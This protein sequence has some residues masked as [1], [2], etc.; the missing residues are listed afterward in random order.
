[1]TAEGCGPQVTGTE[2]LPAGVLLNL[3]HTLPVTDVR[4]H[5]QTHTF[6]VTDSH[7]HTHTT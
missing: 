1:M 3:S 2:L 5:A 7:M 4:V 6:P